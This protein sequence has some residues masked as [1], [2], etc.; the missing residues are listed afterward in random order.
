MVRRESTKSGEISTLAQLDTEMILTVQNKTF[1]NEYDLLTR[2]NLRYYWSGFLEGP[3]PETKIMFP[4]SI[5]SPLPQSEI[6]QT[7]NIAK[8]VSIFY[9]K[10]LKLIVIYKT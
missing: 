5:L 7:A 2:L 10:Y 1:S 6:N 4:R 8:S 9:N 3:M